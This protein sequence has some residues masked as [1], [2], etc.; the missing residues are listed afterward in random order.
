MVLGLDF[1]GFHVRFRD[2]SRGGVRLIKSTPE[3]YETN[4]K[5]QFLENFNLAYTQKLKNKD[6]PE[7]GSKGPCVNTLLRSPTRTCLFAGRYFLFALLMPHR[8]SD[9]VSGTILLK[10]GKNDRDFLAFQQYVDSILDITIKAEGVTDLY[11]QPEYIFLGPDE[12]TAGFMD[13]ACEYA[14]SRNY[15]VW[16]AFT[17]GKSPQLGGIPHDTSVS[18]LRCQSSCTS[19]DFFCVPKGG[20]TV[21]QL[22][23]T[24]LDGT[25]T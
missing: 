1:T 13:G 21:C 20:S 23:L 12:H 5:S 10:Q 25:G 16:R 19:F 14:K 24:L 4:R 18:R 17:T 8:F 7:S 2:I 15:D 11:K 6:I 9:G 22:S 3:S